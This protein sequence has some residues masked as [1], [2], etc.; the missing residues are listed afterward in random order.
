MKAWEIWSYEGHPVIIISNQQR[1]DAKSKV[2]ILKGQSLYSGDAPPGPLEAVLDSEDGMDRRTIF[3]CDLLFTARKSEL[4]QKRGEV[5]YQ[6]R[7]EISRKLI[8][9][10]AI[11]GL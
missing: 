8:Q 5:I 3:T 10:L 6:R 9:G 7:G 11:A 1:V 2:V 4:S